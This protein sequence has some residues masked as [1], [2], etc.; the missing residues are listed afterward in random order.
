MGPVLLMLSGPSGAGKTTVA[1][2]LLAENINLS[3]VVTCT[4]RAPR[5]SEKGGVDYRFLD[6]KE[7]QWR[8]L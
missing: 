1:R 4:T 6:G 8:E 3:Q 5:E 2:R 7:F